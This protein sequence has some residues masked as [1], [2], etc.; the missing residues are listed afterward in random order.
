VTDAEA[1]R[2]VALL[3][4][5]F[6]QELS[7]ETAVIW[8]RELRDYEMVDGQEAARLHGTHDRFMPSLADFVG[9]IVACRNERVRRETPALPAPKD[10]VSWPDFLA[11][12]PDI[13][14][15]AKKRMG[16][17]KDAV[18]AATEDA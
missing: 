3:T 15:R 14:E 10:A 4:A 2:V 16:W 11:A 5:Y 9:Q 7:E 18:D 12:H 13:R 17:F 1:L 8:A 6:R